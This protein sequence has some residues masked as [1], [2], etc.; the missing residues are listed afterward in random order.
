MVLTWK[1]PKQ[2]FTLKLAALETSSQRHIPPRTTGMAL[3]GTAAFQLAPS[4]PPQWLCP[5]LTWRQVL[6]LDP[7]RRDGSTLLSVLPGPVSSGIYV[8]LV[9]GSSSAGPLGNGGSREP[10]ALP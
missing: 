6:G 2:P 5:W 4:C 8:P 9:S 10:V 3:P 7:A 1:K